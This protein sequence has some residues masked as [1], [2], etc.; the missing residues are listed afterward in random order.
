MNNFILI[1][2][3]AAFPPLSTDMYLPAIPTLC[4]IWGITLAQANLS[5]V[6]FFVSFSAFL[7][8]HGPLADRFGRRPVL[9]GGVSLYIAGSLSCAGADSITFLVLSR[10][11]QACGAAAGSAMALALTKDLY[12]GN[13]QKKILAYIGVLIP[14]CPMVAPSIG[15]LILQYASWRSIFLAQAILTLP[16]LYGAFRLKEPMTTEH[17]GTGGVSAAIRRYGRLARNGAYM[18]YTLAFSVMG[19]SFFAF[20]GGSS[21][22]YIRSF[23][24]TEQIYSLYFGFN[25][26][27]L[28]LGSLLCA[29][30]LVNFESR[31]ILFI[32][33]VGMFFSTG[34]LLFL[35]KATPTNFALSMFAYSLFLGM[36]RPISNH[37]ILKQV[38][39]DTGTA[40][41]LLTFFNF[42][43]AAVA[44]ELI[45]PD[46]SSKPMV[47]GVMGLVG[48]TI[49]FAAILAM[50]RG[51]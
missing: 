27:A 28:T 22:I 36:S 46:W 20:L 33:L 49:P 18:V 6:V 10:I 1:I 29:R 40:S 3:L 16:A 2:L 43:C 12:R 14:L 38:R 39:Q 23:G 17:S 50:Q 37:L 30:V 8:L 41:S 15:A 45:S 24:M 26:L 42:L 25:A 4:T 32:T 21:D 48:S 35:G 19:F 9:I 5:L 13:E 11:I 31:R 51:K 7:L 44:M 47:I 34:T